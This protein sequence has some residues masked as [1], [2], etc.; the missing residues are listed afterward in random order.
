MPTTR[1]P[2]RIRLDN[3]DEG[4]PGLAKEVAQVMYGAT[5]V[6]FERHNHKSPAR[7]LSENLTTLEER[8][9]SGQWD[10]PDDKLKRSFQ[11][12]ERIERTAECVALALLRA[13]H[14][15]R[16]FGRAEELSGS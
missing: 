11:P 13:Q 15:Y 16:V 2:V 4:S 10:L 14:N 6:S 3:L 8:H 5:R 7:I 9:G 12:K 1:L